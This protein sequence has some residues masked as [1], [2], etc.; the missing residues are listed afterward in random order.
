MTVDNAKKYS[1]LV[2]FRSLP[3]DYG[4]T[5]PASICGGVRFLKCRPAVNAVGPPHNARFQ[6]LFRDLGHDYWHGRNLY[7]PPLQHEIKWKSRLRNMVF[8]MV[9]LCESAYS[10]IRSLPAWYEPWPNP[11]WQL[12]LYFVAPKWITSDNDGV[13]RWHFCCLLIR[14]APKPFLCLTEQPVHGANEEKKW[15]SCSLLVSG[16]NGL[17][18]SIV[19]AY[20]SSYPS[21]Y[22]I[23]QRLHLRTDFCHF[24]IRKWK[25][26]KTKPVACGIVNRHPITSFYTQGLPFYVCIWN[27]ISFIIQLPHLLHWLPRILNKW[28]ERKYCRRTDMAWDYFVAKN[29]NDVLLVLR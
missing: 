2:L 19:K 22:D 4:F 1:Y 5:R 16:D 12:Y 6:H 20:P 13:S 28:K 7:A 25:Y 27:E 23:H 29:L 11:H 26:W 10:R 24:L 9:K 15:K 21:S 8:S 18:Q 17:H 3:L 14:K